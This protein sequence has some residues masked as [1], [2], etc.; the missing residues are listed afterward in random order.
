MSTSIGEIADQLMN[1]GGQ[2]W[3][4]ESDAAQKFWELASRVSLIGAQL[5]VMSVPYMT[6]S[7]IV[8]AARKSLEREMA[9]LIAENHV[10]LTDDDVELTAET[11]EMDA[12]GAFVPSL[13][14]TIKT[15]RYSLTVKATLDE[16]IDDKLVYKLE[17]QSSERFDLPSDHDEYASDDYAYRSDLKALAAK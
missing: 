12:D 4:N 7:A 14:V 17:K 13:D 15:D 10:E 8:R 1:V 5:K 6:G 16:I 2:V 9:E 3:M 11:L